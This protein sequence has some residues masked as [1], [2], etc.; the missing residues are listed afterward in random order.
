MGSTM[1]L[2]TKWVFN[3]GAHRR[4]SN[5]AQAAFMMVVVT[6]MPMTSKSTFCLCLVAAFITTV[7]QGLKSEKY[8]V[9]AM[10]VS[11]QYALVEL[12]ELE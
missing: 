6:T 3:D 1:E 8:E 12:C 11:S 9:N 10:L 5:I 2:A 4:C 7:L